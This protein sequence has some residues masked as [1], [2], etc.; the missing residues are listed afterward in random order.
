M[1]GSV[2]A[3]RRRAQSNC[4]QGIVNVE[5][6]REREREQELSTETREA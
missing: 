4:E 5:P 2:F 6:N 1:F 3:V